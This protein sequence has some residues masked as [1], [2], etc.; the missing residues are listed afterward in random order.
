MFLTI[1][2]LKTFNFLNFLGIDLPRSLPLF[3]YLIENLNNDLL[4]FQ[5][6]CFFFL[7][8]GGQ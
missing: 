5:L 4:I 2:Q 6:M 7:V 3:L 8:L 1:T